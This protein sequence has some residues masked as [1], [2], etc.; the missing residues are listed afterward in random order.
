MRN[1][2]M[3]NN[4]FN[5]YLLHL[6]ELKSFAVTIPQSLAVINILILSGVMGWGETNST[7]IYHNN[8]R[9]VFGYYKVHYTVSFT[10]FPTVLFE[11]SV[12]LLCMHNMSRYC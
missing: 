5:I 4:V 10:S 3:Q 6:F 11:K 8:S 1:I 2:L 12:R 9:K 7:S